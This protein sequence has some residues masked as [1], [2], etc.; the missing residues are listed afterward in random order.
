MLFKR[1]PGKICSNSSHDR[2]A[3]FYLSQQSITKQMTHV[4]DADSGS[5]LCTDL[6]R[7]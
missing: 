1:L 2:A 3:L 6:W 4:L 7:T 5:N